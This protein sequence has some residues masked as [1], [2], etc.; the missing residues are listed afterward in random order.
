MWYSMILAASV[1]ANPEGVRFF[2]GSWND[3]LK[4]AEKAKKLVF[5]DFSTVW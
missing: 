2:E 1:L 5:A 4:E 3:A